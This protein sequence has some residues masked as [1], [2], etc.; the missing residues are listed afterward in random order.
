MILETS[1]LYLTT[2]VTFISTPHATLQL[3]T[4]IASDLCS[5]GLRI[6]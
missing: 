5:E 3:R 1:N 6:C 4:I 2:V